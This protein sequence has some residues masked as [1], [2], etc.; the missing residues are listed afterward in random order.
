MRQITDSI[1][2][3]GFPFNAIFRLKKIASGCFNSKSCIDFEVKLTFYIFRF[4][5]HFSCIEFIT[6]FFKK[7]NINS[8]LT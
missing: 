4:V 3:R 2:S 5:S 1:G 7:V 8:I 6:K